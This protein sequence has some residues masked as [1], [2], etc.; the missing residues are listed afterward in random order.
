MDGRKSS[1]E[2]TNVHGD[3]RS[4]FRRDTEGGGW[5]VGVPVFSPTLGPLSFLASGFPV[6]WH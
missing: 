6:L 1:P 3:S 5:G 4:A 2:Y